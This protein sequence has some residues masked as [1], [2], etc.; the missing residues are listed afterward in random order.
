[1]TCAADCEESKSPEAG[2]SGETLGSFMLNA[3][4]DKSLEPGQV[5]DFSITA[6]C[7]EGGR[8]ISCSTF[9]C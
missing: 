6:T 2:A 8:A 9:A 1:V 5:Y 3:A 7:A 4:I